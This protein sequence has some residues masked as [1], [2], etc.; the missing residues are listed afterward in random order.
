LC[1]L[2]CVDEAAHNL[3]ALQLVKQPLGHHLLVLDQLPV[4]HS[5][6]CREVLHELRVVAVVLS[7]VYE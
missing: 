5:I 1:L 3:G 7:P 2:D 4:V 6:K